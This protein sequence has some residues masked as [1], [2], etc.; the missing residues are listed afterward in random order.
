[1]RQLSKY[2]DKHN[3]EVIYCEAEGVKIIR[4]TARITTCIYNKIMNETCMK[5]NDN[6]GK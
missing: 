3:E 6:T 2:T 4:V 5:H 1:L